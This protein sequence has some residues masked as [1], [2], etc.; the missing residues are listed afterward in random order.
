MKKK[1]ILAAALALC[2]AFCSGQ[3]VSMADMRPAAGSTA[4]RDIT[5]QQFAIKDYLPE[6]EIGD[7][8]KITVDVH[9]NGGYAAAIQAN[10]PEGW[11]Q[12][13][14]WGSNDSQVNS[15]TCIPTDGKASVIL[16]YVSDECDWFMFNVRVELVE[17]VKPPED[18][19]ERALKQIE[20]KRYEDALMMKGIAK[21]K[22]RKY[23]FMFAVQSPAFVFPT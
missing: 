14:Q 21:E 7:K 1:G 6:Y 8:V 15:Y 5:S 2:L 17:K 23:G 11:T 13:E 18:T 12:S 22:I 10:T 19:A 16:W 3:I 9:A 20:E 4:M